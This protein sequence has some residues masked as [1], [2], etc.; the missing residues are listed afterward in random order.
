MLLA[1]VA[2]DTFC[3]TESP[4]ALYVLDISDMKQF[5]VHL[6]SSSISQLI[7]RI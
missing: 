3:S 1:V 5:I 6:K 2:V 7:N 4:T